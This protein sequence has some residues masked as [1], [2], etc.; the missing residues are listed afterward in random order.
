MTLASQREPATCCLLRH[1]EFAVDTAHE[2]GQLTLHYFRAGVETEFKQDGT[3]VTAVDRATEA[4]IRS[5]VEKRYPLHDLLGEEYGAKNVDG[6]SHRWFIDPI[7]GTESFAVGKP[8]YGVLIGLEI[9]GICAVGAAYFPALDE[10]IYAATGHGC[11]WNA[12]PA[13]VSN[14]ASLRSSV[15]SLATRAA[16]TDA[17][18]LDEMRRIQRACSRSIGQRDGYGHALVA[19]GRLEAALDPIMQP[20]DAGPFPVILREAGGYFGDWSGNETIHCREAL[21]TTRA[22][23]PSLLKCIEG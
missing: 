2:A 23:L 10:M 11:F 1:L 19:T 4:L 17:D 8:Y 16:F 13:H 9:D 12:R 5:R 15:V 18:R 20:W 14:T 21:S 3:P 7:D 6:A 22:L